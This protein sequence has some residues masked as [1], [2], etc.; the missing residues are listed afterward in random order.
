MDAFLRELTL[1][2]RQKR[3]LETFSCSWKSKS[4]YVK[5]KLSGEDLKAGATDDKTAN[6]TK[7]GNA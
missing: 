1:M 6:L 3:G 5:N 4:I 2:L 7:A